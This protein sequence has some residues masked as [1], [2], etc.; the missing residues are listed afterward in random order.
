[1]TKLEKMRD[2]LAEKR[3]MKQC[4]SG[5]EHTD[6][7]WQKHLRIGFEDGFDAADAHYRP[8]VDE[9]VKALEFAALPMHI[10]VS[11]REAADRRWLIQDKARAAL[12][13]VR[14]KL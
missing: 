3:A 12:E 9:L 14:G 10:Q 5:C 1:M 7:V 4:S 11:D 2:E 6:K 13:I 8:I